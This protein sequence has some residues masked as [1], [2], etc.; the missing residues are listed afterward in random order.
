MG[1]DAVTAKI[2]KLPS[3]TLQ[4]L[5]TKIQVEIFNYLRDA[6]SACLGVTCK[7]FYSIYWELHGKVGLQAKTLN[8]A[9]F[10]TLHAGLKDWMG[11][12]MEHH[13]WMNMFLTKE[14]QIAVHKNIQRSLDGTTRGFWDTD[15][16]F[17]GMKRDIFRIRMEFREAG[18]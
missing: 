6:H 12:D 10:F 9:R 1:N 17:A 2:Q 13:P 4:T 7:Q 11:P 14:R 5:P 18:V 16:H 15:L 3:P 8:R